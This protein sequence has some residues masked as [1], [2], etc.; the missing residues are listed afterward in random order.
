VENDGAQFVLTALPDAV[1]VQP[2]PRAAL[3]KEFSAR[4]PP[5]YDV[6]YPQTRLQQFAATWGIPYLN[7]VPIFR[8]YR[9]QHQLQLPY[10]SYAHDGH[11]SPLGHE[12]AAQA[13]ARFLLEEGFVRPGK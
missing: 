1:Q 13:V 2:H 4:L 11:W 12:V 10:F 7:L 5:E 9:D 3:E 6:D 8:D